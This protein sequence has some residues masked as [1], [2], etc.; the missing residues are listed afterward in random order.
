MHRGN[1]IKLQGCGLIKKTV[2]TEAKKKITHDQTR[3]EIMNL[4]KVVEKIRLKI[5][6]T[7]EKNRFCNY[8]E[9]S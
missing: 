4:M 1:V 3:I 7:F 2:M 5:K 8:K 9:L 6:I